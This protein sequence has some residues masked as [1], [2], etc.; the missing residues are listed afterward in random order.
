M[1]KATPEAIHAYIQAFRI[2]DLGIASIPFEVFTETGLEIKSR[3]PFK[4]TRL[5]GRTARHSAS[6]ERRAS[7]ARRRR[8]GYPSHQSKCL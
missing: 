1:H 7:A 5:P 2:G 6:R 3:S 8:H 4:D